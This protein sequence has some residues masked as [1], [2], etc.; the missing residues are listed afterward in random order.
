MSWL[1]RSKRYQDA[2]T[3]LIRV[4]ETSSG[5]AEIRQDGVDEFERL[6]DLFSDLGTGE[7]NLSRDE[8]QEHDLGL[9]HAVDETR[10]EL[11]LVGAESVM[12][13]SQTLQ[14]NGELDVC[15]ADN[16]LDLEVGE[17]GAQLANM[18]ETGHMR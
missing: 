18:F 12:V 15:G 8:D 2:A 1:M 5:L 6:V 13:R 11:R 10:E 4:D 17:L 9:H 3:L 16:V 14:T 7:D